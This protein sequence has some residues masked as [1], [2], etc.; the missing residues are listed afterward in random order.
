MKF[1]RRLRWS[2]SIALFLGALTLLPMQVASASVTKPRATTTT[3]NVTS[4]AATATGY[5][6]AYCGP[7][8]WALVNWY[9]NP[10]WPLDYRYQVGQGVNVQWHWTSVP[11]LSIFPPFWWG[12][13][14]TVS[15][16]WTPPSFY[17]A[18]YFLCSSPS[19]VEITPYNLPTAPA[20]LM[21]AA[22]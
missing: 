15:H 11:V 17:T 6:Y 21:F 18:V 10:A 4:A 16:I 1:S 13:F 14:T 3:A 7:D 19:V 9:V 8:E 22:R 20:G 2:A 12:S 5:S